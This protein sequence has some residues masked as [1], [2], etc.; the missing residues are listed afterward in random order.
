[1]DRERDKG[2]RR[3]QTLSHL[4]VTHRVTAGSSKK[5]IQIR[6]GIDNA[7]ETLLGKKPSLSV[8]REEK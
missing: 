6:L 5:I 7:M 3:G 8:E 2:L 4:V 1:M